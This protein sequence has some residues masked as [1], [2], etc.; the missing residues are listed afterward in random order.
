MFKNIS[1]VTSAKTDS[2]PAQFYNANEKKAEIS[3]VLKETHEHKSN[4]RQMKIIASISAGLI[5]ATTTCGVLAGGYSLGYT[6]KVD[7]TVVGTVAAKSEYYE[8]LDEVKTEVKDIADVEFEPKGEE[9]FQVEIVKRSDL[10]DKTQLAENLKSTQ[11]GMVEAASITVG[12]VFFAAVP[13]EHEAHNLMEKYLVGYTAAQENITAE[14]ADEVKISAGY[15]PAESVKTPE[16][17]YEMLLM[18]K[19]VSHVAAEGETAE[20]IAA[21]Y[22]TTVESL[23]EINEIKK[24]EAGMSVTVY[25]GEPLF[26]VKTIEH[27]GGE[28]EIPFEIVQEENPDLYEG[29][30]QVKTEGVPGARFKD[31]YITRINGEIV[32]ENVITD[33]IIREPVAQVEYVGTKEAPPSVGTGTF[34]M[35]TSGKLTSPYGARW[36]R[37]HAGIDVGAKTGTPIYAADNGIVTVSEFKNNGYGNFVS[38]DHG[39]GFVTYYAHCSEL[40]VKEGDV[41]AKGDLIAKVG[42]TGRSTGPH[43]HFEIRLDGTAQNPLNYVG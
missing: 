4:K 31:A 23:L 1:N 26:D 19:T 36:G 35:P 42:N 29:R 11:D 22:N 12:D 8:V 15:V 9:S 33:E 27:I 24:I 39:N 34:A 10:T 40:L 28:E 3:S 37:T 2:V 14:F 43:L 38:I 32:E 17:V 21:L 13:A 30:T 5:C 20:S 16:A 41:V 25:T 6:V 18:G 7:N